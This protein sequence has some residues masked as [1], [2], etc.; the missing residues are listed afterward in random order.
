[1]T[2]SAFCISIAAQTKVLWR[3]GLCMV[4]C[5]LVSNTIDM[6]VDNHTYDMGFFI[7][8]DTVLGICT[9]SLLQLYQSK[10]ARLISL[11]FMCSAI[12]NTVG[13][14]AKLYF[15]AY[16]FPHCLLANIIFAL[17][18]SCVVAPS[19]YLTVVNYKAPEKKST[20]RNQTYRI[21]LI[22]SVNG[23]YAAR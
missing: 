6:L 5:W 20:I 23:Q 12:V 7:L 16:K 15:P 4:I 8:A 14:L 2:L 17:Q 1:M 19:V 10:T 18:V 21:N 3:L 22:G 13:I 9:Y 11:L